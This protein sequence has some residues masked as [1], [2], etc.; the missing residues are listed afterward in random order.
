MV[1][2]L[3]IAI[4]SRYSGFGGQRECALLPVGR[5]LL[6]FWVANGVQGARIGLPSRGVSVSIQV[7]NQRPKQF[8]YYSDR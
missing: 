5:E 1:L 8:F 2:L 7:E 4:L 3:T 6:F